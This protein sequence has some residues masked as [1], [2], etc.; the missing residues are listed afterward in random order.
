MHSPK[1][2][3]CP[4]QQNRP[5]QLPWSPPTPFP[6]T[7]VHGRPTRRNYETLKE[8]ASSLASK[9]KDITYAWSKNAM[10]N[11]RLLTNILGADK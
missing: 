3:S 9:V 11:Y 4:P 2:L 6:I 8:E 7:R 10:D 1:N 5:K